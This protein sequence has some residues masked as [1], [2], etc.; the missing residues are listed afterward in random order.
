MF[1]HMNIHPGKL[2]APLRWSK[3]VIQAD[4]KRV[5]WHT[6][7]LNKS[8]KSTQTLKHLDLNALRPCT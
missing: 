7:L 2:C 1:H 6:V 8:W 4:M 5:F 3:S